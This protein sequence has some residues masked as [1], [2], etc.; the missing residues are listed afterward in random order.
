MQESRE[1][2][3]EAGRVGR[4]GR[5]S[6]EDSRRGEQRGGREAHKSIDLELLHVRS[7]ADLEGSGLQ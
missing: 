7:V 1:R 5:E 3:R 6:G 4:S 2:R